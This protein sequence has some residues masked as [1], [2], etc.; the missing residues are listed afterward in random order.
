[1]HLRPLGHLSHEARRPRAARGAVIARL[2]E[3]LTTRCRACTVRGG[4]LSE[5]PKEPDSKSGVPVRVPWV[6]IPRSPLTFLGVALAGA[7]PHLLLQL[8][9]ALC[10]VLVPPTA[11]RRSCRTSASEATRGEDSCDLAQL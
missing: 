2:F 3:R 4:E 5:W 6:R 8:D 10:E 1:M 11:A 7:P 9:V